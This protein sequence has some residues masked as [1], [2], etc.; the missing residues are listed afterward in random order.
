M[1]NKGEKSEQ[2]DKQTEDTQHGGKNKS[3]KATREA[4]LMFNVNTVKNYVDTFYKTQGLTKP[5]YYGGQVA[6][7]AFLQELSSLLLRNVLKMTQKDQSGMF[8]VNRGTFMLSVSNNQELRRYYANNMETFNKNSVYVKSELVEAKEMD[9]LMNT[10]EKNLKLTPKAYNFF[11]YLLDTAFTEVLH[12]ANYFIEFAEK[13]SLDGRAV[14]Y[15]VQVHFTG[16][17]CQSLLSEVSKAMKLSGDDVEMGGKD[18]DVVNKPVEQTM[19][20]NNDSDD[21][22]KQETTEVKETKETK[23]VKETKPKS[24]KTSTKETKETKKNTKQTKPEPIEQDNDELPNDD[25]KTQE[26]DDVKQVEDKTKKTP[27]KQPVKN[28]GKTQTAKK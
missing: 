25:Q 11:F 7:T 22:Q 13:K 26:V 19:T 27:Q 2:T 23:E 9:E 14:M 4:G 17:A 10:V 20:V 6:M 12:T 5:K 21:E 1:V 18:E 24:E 15:A 3:N 8:N 28:Q 16:D